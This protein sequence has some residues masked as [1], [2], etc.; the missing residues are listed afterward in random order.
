M[1][2]EDLLK[3]KEKITKLSD[4][5]K[6]ERD[7]YLRGLANGEIQGP[8]V[9]YASIDKPWLKHFSD[10]QMNAEEVHKTAYRYL[11]DENK[12]F[13]NDVAIIFPFLSFLSTSLAIVWFPI[14]HG[15]L[16]VWCAS[17]KL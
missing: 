16:Q 7:L 1:T 15:T 9:G 6:K 12:N 14:A 2:K 11:Y 10:E 17:M 8:S 3:L 5:E 13:E 4:E